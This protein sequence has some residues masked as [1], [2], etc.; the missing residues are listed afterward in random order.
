MSERF[1]P[2]LLE[3][4]RKIAAR[5][6]AV[7]HCAHCNT[8]WTIGEYDPG[9]TDALAELVQAARRV[10]EEDEAL[11]RFDDDGGLRHALTTVISEAAPKRHCSH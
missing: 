1:D 6:G 9:D 11:D 3:A 8:T 7:G 10:V 5:C 4:A 2:E